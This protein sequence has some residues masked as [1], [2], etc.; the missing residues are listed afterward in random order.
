MFHNI[1]TDLG[2]TPRKPT[3]IYNDNH[4]TVE[5]SHSFSA[6][7]MHHLNI[8]ENAVREAQQLQE[9][10]IGHIDGTCNPANI[11]TKEFKSDSTFCS[12]RDLLLYLTSSFSCSSLAWGMLGHLEIRNSRI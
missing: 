7:G 6:K 11:F 10:S 8:Q 1:L 2:L 12:L 4:G 3:P 9:V 5:W